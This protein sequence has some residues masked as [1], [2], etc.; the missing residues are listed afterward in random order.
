METS[1]LMT[2]IQ[3]GIKQMIMSKIPNIDIN[4]LHG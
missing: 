3:L 2:A 1:P 4:T